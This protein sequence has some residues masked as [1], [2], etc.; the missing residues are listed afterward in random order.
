MSSKKSSVFSGHRKPLTKPASNKAVKKGSH[1]HPK[2]VP[3]LAKLSGRGGI[4]L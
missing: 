4:R 1:V 2:N 3:S